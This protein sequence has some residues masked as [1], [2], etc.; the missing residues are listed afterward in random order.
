M[1]CGGAAGSQINPV[2]FP[3]M[4]LRP[5]GWAGLYGTP[6]S[7][8]PLCCRPTQE[9][10]LQEEE[11]AFQ[12]EAQIEEE[13]IPYA[14]A[15]LGLTSAQKSRC[16]VG[17]QI[18]GAIPKRVGPLAEL[19]LGTRNPRFVVWPLELGLGTHNPRFVVWPLELGLRTHNPRFHYWGTRTQYTRSAQ[20]PPPRGCVRGRMCE[21][22]EHCVATFVLIIETLKEGLFLFVVL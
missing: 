1:L 9:K 3:G 20:S 14:L 5:M 22:C 6:R 18:S 17:F 10:E 19:E 21:Q 15:H 12:E 2:S 7:Q 11:K 13:S 8:I 16:L 4:H